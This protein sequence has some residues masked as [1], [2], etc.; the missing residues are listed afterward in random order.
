VKFVVQ[1]W[2]RIAA[3]CVASIL[4]S[5]ACWAQLAFPGAVGFGAQ[6]TGGRG[7]TIYHVTN[8]NN[9][10]A[11]SFRD[12]VSTGNRIVVFDVGGYIVLSSPVSVASNITVEGQTAP[13]GGIGIMAAEVSLSNRS[14]IIL[15]G[16]RIRQGTED[17]KTGKSALGM[18]N[19]SNII[20]DHCSFEYGQWDSIDAVKT[21]NFTV[22]NSIIANP[23]YQQFGAHVEGGPSTFYRNLWVNGHN[24]QPL[25][26]DNTLY[27]NNVVYDYQAGYT[28]GN[29][30]GT[31][32]HDIVNNYFIAG[33]RTTS[34]SNLYFQVNSNQTIYAVGNMLDGNRDGV[35]NGSG[36]NTVGSAI[37]T[38]TPWS[39]L[40]ATIS[41]LSAAD[42]YPLVVASA[43]AFPRDEVDAF[44]VSDVQSLGTAGTL[45]KDQANTG[46]END[47][48][49]VIA[50][51]TPF[52]D[53]NSDGIPDYWASA[54]GI[55]T[56]DA[57][58]GTASYGSTGYTNLE[59]Y[60]NSLILPDLWSAADLNTPPT[61]G[62]SSYNSFAGTW[63]LTGSSA[64][65]ST[66]FDQGQFASRAWAAD[67]TLA[68]QVTTVSGGA[69]GLMARAD[70]NA[71]SA[72]AAITV[73][74]NGQVAFQWR[75][76]DSGVAGGVQKSNLSAPVYLKLVRQNGTVA[77]YASTDNANWTLVGLAQVALTEK[78]VAGMIVASSSA[79]LAT[80]QFATVDFADTAASVVS[81]QSSSTAITYPA[82]IN[83][84]ATVTAE[85]TATG[86]VQFWDGGTALTAQPLQGGGAAYWYLQPALSAGSHTLTASYAG[87]A[88]NL[89]GFSDPLT[90]TVA[91][92]PVALSAACWNESF[93]YGAD[94]QCTANV[95]SNAGAPAGALR[96]SL[97]GVSSA[98]ALNNGT[99]QWTVSKPEAGTHAV[100]IWFEGQGNFA[101]SSVV[102]KAFTVMP[103]TV[104]LQLSPS[105]YYQS[106]SAPFTLKAVLRTW[107]APV[108]TAGS[109]VFYDN[110][111]AVGAADLAADGSASLTLNSLSAGAHSL[112]AVYAGSTN[113]SAANSSAVSVQTY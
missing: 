27:I 94:Y 62:A 4:G 99:A 41:T 35:L 18:S 39:S 11:G 29:T 33:P 37:L 57:S 92:T 30:G 19:A 3:L 75:S 104:Q 108:P 63:L 68:G 74:C 96:H 105:S 80:A 56:T 40:T 97:D 113:Y 59:V 110:G 10:G 5:G 7:G 101:A 58:A 6:A 87:D 64:A 52:A 82:S 32:S 72:Y 84:T 48:Y 98:A 93:A 51:G 60:A 17:P 28:V 103:A 24:R 15:R 69:A 77:G 107:S 13:G 46:I 8:L 14:N 102:S 106:A 70:T 73:N 79:T 90:I 112:A 83:L 89:A 111:V 100:S 49:G 1:Q 36:A 53:A 12:A 76:V 109:I 38:T 44:V 95:S 55:S 50:S 23:I 43:G 78:A 45:Y 54:Y 22:S 42:A 31:F 2:S 67:G 26:K 71:D 86:T 88:N 9:S 91:Q 65:N 16:L 61:A 34:T 47:G 20:L 81:L 25:A 66:G 85:K 21:A